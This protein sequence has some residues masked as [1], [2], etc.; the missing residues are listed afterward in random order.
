MCSSTRPNSPKCALLSALFASACSFRS[1][2]LQKARP[3]PVSTTA[4][5]RV[6]GVDLVQSREQFGARL[7]SQRVHRRIVDLQ[8]RHM[9]GRHGEMNTA[10]FAPLREPVG[11]SLRGSLCRASSSAAIWPASTNG[12]AVRRPRSATVGTPPFRSAPNRAGY[13][14]VLGQLRP[15]VPRS[16]LRNAPAMKGLTSGSCMMFASTTQSPHQFPPRSMKTHLPLLRA[17]AKAAA[18]SASAFAV[19]S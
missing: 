17:R 18:T 6:S 14:Q 1:S 11:D 19:S 12:L 7:A 8:Q 13:L 16:R 15:T 10:H 3:R 5:K 4:R 9:A 2:P